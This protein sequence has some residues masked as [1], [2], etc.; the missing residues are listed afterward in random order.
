MASLAPPLLCAP[1]P[2]LQHRRRAISLM[3]RR[4]LVAMSVS[5]LS[6]LSSGVSGIWAMARL[7]LDR[8]RRVGVDGA[9]FGHS[10]WRW[11]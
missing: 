8:Q 3:A 6:M 2:E 10:G 1:Q 4:A 5:K 9:A 7:P 11:R